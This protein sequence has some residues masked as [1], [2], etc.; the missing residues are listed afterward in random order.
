MFT[1]TRH[2]LQTI[3]RDP[4]TQRIR[5]IKPEE[6][7]ETVWDGLDKTA[8]A[9]SWVPGDNSDGID[10]NA[11]ESFQAS[12]VYTEADELEDALLFPS[13]ASG[14]MA[15]NLFRNN[16]SAM[17]IFEKETIDVRKFAA[18][19]DTDDEMSADLDEDTPYGSDLIDEDLD[20]LE[21]DDGDSNWDTD[22]EESD[23]GGAH[24]RS[25]FITA[26][27]QDAI[28]R[29]IDM[30]A[31][32]MTSTRSRE[33]DYFLP[34]LRNPSRAQGIPAIVKNDPTSLMTALRNAL[35]C[36]QEYNSSSM[37]ME[38]D[39]FRHVDRQKS[40]GRSLMPD[41]NRIDAN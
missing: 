14:E 22:E 10:A 23:A 24:G 37:G 12:Y 18:D 38:A 33:P 6:D 8:G 9:F 1:A 40:K 16:P 35:R 29:T 36:S 27:E 5:S 19:L 4:K 15:D 7:V 3:T 39:F 13:E 2:I 31:D 30:L 21:D 28:D 32:Q 26:E 17:E 34:I 11:D 25:S 41:W 20:D